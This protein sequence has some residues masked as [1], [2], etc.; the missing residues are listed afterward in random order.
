MSKDNKTNVMRRLD[1]VKV[2]YEGIEAE[3]LR[4]QDHIPIYKTLVTEG[5]SGENYVFE[6]A[7]NS[8][9]DLKKAAQAVG[10]KKIHMIKEKELEPLTGY[11]HGGCSPI[12]MKKDFPTVIDQSAFD[13][14]KMAF[15]AGRVGFSVIMK[16]ED[17][18][19]IIDAKVADIQ[20][21]KE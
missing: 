11:V 21:E 15:S 13:Y 19:K 5:K 18:Q 17:L 16:P 8:E 10:E 7:I 20:E 1:Q 4:Q 3:D 14:E 12:G 2:D 6:V 9:L